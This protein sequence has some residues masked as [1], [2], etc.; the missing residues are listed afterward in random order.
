MSE[1][2]ETR[3]EVAPFRWVSIGAQAF[4]FWLLITLASTLENG[5]FHIVSIRVSLRFELT[6]WMPWAF[7]T[8]IMIWAA[9][10]YPIEKNAWRRNLRLHLLLCVAFVGGL[11]W[12]GYWAG[13]PP[14]FASLSHEFEQMKEHNPFYL[15]LLCLTFQL[16]TF[17]AVTGVAHALH[18]YQSAKNKERHEAELEAR[19][20]QARLQALR[21][22]L[23]PH[24]LFNTLNSISSLIDVNPKA[25]DEMIG[26]LSDLLRA[27]LRATNRQEVSLREEIEFMDSYLA[28]QK[29]R[30]GSRLNVDKVIDPQTLHAQVPILILQP[31]VENAI[32]HGIEPR[33]TPGQISI[34]AA[35]EGKHLLLRIADNGPGLS[36]ALPQ[37]GI[38]LKNTVARL[39]ELY[40]PNAQ[41]HAGEQ[42]RGGFQV[43]IRIPWN[44]SSELNPNPLPAL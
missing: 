17:L 41:F 11:G 36:S 28:I 40:G 16:P 19:L 43:E 9:S 14:Y 44:T 33:S 2:I 24:F 32:I 10:A 38:G 29:Q 27:T 15:N 5:L 21:M 26:Q 22:Q 6:H 18:F 7:L 20:A 31:L 34:Q 13:P 1:A 3:P 39:K 35:I 37:G 4:I 8:P 42:A 25:A 12:I 23:N 30:F